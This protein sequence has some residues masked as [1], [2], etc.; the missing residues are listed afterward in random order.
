M[1]G[2]NPPKPEKTYC[3]DLIDN[4]VQ[5]AIGIDVITRDYRYNSAIMKVNY[6]TPDGERFLTV[7]VKPGIHNE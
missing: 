4:I 6:Q 2:T 5:H 1:T 7:I 3:G